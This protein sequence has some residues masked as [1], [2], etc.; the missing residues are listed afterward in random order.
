VV[1]GI[2]ANVA[3]EVVVFQHE[4]P[5]IETVFAPVGEDVTCFPPT[6]FARLGEQECAA[7]AIDAGD[8]RVRLEHQLSMPDPSLA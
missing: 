5:S 3:I 7:A 1:P 2:T 6:V 4:V 8:L